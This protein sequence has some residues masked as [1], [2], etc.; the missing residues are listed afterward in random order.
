MNVNIKPIIESLERAS[1]PNY[2]GL[3][4]EPL[5]KKLEAFTGDSFTNDNWPP[6]DLIQEKDGYVYKFAIAGFKKEDISIELDR[7][8]SFLSISGDKKKSKEEKISYIHNGIAERKFRKK[9]FMT[10]DLTVTKATV[11]D[12]IL[13]IYLKENKKEVEKPVIIPIQ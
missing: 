12:G 5:W 9:I 3:G 11:E 10:E 4:Y 7:V 1:R 6:Y 13:S 2:S 8:N